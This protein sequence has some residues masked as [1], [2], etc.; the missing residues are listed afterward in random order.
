MGIRPGAA[1][2]GLLVMPGLVFAVFMTA[3]YGRWSPRFSWL[4]RLTFG[5]YLVHPIFIDL[6][7][8]ALYGSGWSLPPTVMVLTK[9]VFTVAAAFALSY[10]LSK[11][12]PLAWLIGLGP[13]PLLPQKL[14]TAEA[15][16]HA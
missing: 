7:D 2:Y 11:I 5:I 4:A 14:S 1:F 16:R 8:I 10:I 6:Y 3:Q 15:A 9:Y 12:R 13:V